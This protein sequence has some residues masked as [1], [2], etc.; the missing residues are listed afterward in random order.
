[1][2]RRRP[3]KRRPR[4]AE[5]DKCVV[6]HKTGQRVCFSIHYDYEGKLLGKVCSLCTASD[7]MEVLTY[8]RKEP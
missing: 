6:C 1:M 8:L 4:T 2:A 7:A 3:F 5:G